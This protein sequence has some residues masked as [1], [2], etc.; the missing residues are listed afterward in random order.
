MLRLIKIVILSTF[1]LFITIA[2]QTFS[3]KATNP[4]IL[5]ENTQVN[6]YEEK[7]NQELEKLK[8][9]LKQDEQEL[10]KKVSLTILKNII[11][12]DKNIALEQ[13]QTKEIYGN[14][15]KEICI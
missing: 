5:Q 10:Y 9:Q 12:E 2:L 1:L 15:N 7:P 14:T 6:F 8:T 11:Q 4:P 13:S 3:L